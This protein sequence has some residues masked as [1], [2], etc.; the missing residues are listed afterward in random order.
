M[1]LAAKKI[2]QKH[3]GF[4][5]FRPIQEEII[6]TVLE[7]KDCL[8]LLPTGGGKSICFQIPTLLKEGICLVISP[9]IALMKD[10]VEGLHKKGITASSIQTG[11][12]NE[13]IKNILEETEKGNFKFLY[14]S[15]ERLESNLFLEFLP[16]LNIQLITVDEA[17]CISQW[18]YDFRPSYLKIASIKKILPKIPTLALTATATEK[19]QKDICNKL[20]FQHETIV[21]SS[22]EKPNVSFS[23]FTEDSKINKLIEILQKVS[24][25][26]IVYCKNRRRTK[27]VCDLLLAQKISAQYYH[28]GLTQEERNTIQESWIQNKTRVIVCTNA[29][30]MGIDK[31]DVRCVIHYDSTDCIENYYQEAGRAGRDEKKSYAVLLCTVEDIEQL[32]FLPDKKYPDIK[33]IKSIYGDIANYLQLPKGLGEGLYFDFDLS[34][35]AKNFKYDVHLTLATLKILEQEGHCSFS[36][37]VFLPSKAGFIINKESLFE[38]ENRYPYLEPLV[39]TLLRTYSGIFDFTVNINEKQ[40]SKLLKQRIEK[41]QADL[42]ELKKLGVIEY[43]PQKDT[44]QIYFNNNRAIANELFINNTQYFNRKQEYDYR[45]K[46]MVQYIQNKSYCRSKQLIEY[47][48]IAILND[49]GIC[50][51]CLQRKKINLSAQELKTISNQIIQQLSTEGILVNNLL[52]KLH[53]LKKEKIWWVLDQLQSER[54]IEL[55]ADGYFKKLK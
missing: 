48:N 25:S 29:F 46:S 11:L 26:A 2:L 5:N 37:S 33:T 35:F 18:G 4:E 3:W 38:F 32:K 41:T 43:H 28:A 39:K 40:L 30:G 53:T 12:S 51:N 16:H 54:V 45:V 27:E 9:L 21:K 42:V 8:A 49:C 47:F 14:V 15:P 22:F 34:E 13:E 7:G 36:E 24:G 17:H 44:A 1:L 10:Q 19:V 52:A 6:Q 55:T 50:D 23:V 20:L 31:P